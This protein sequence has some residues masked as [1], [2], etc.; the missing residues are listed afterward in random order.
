MSSEIPYKGTVR[1]KGISL[2]GNTGGESRTEE[3]PNALK[4]GEE[5]NERI[6]KQECS[7]AFR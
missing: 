2:A 4:I 7:L 1:L 6:R 5:R 3:K